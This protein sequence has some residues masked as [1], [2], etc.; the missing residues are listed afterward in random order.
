M[1]HL[2]F[3]LGFVPL[4]G[5]VLAA[6][7]LAAARRDP[8]AAGWKRPLLAVL[9]FDAVAWPLFSC[10]WLFGEPLIPPAVA[11]DD[12]LGF[13]FWSIW[14][15]VFVRIVQIVVLVAMALY[16]RKSSRRASLAL[17][18]VLFAML[19]MEV[20]STLPAWLP[21]IDLLFFK[22]DRGVRL[23]VLK[24]PSA[25]ALLAM[26]VVAYLWMRKRFD[27]RDDPAGRLSRA[28]GFGL[29]LLYLFAGMI[30]YIALCKTVKVLFPPDMTAPDPG[31][32]DPVTSAL[33]MVLARAPL[34]VLLAPLSEE[35][36]F[37]G[38][39]FPGLRS[40]IALWKAY[41]LSSLAFAL[42]HHLHGINILD[43]LWFGLVMAWARHRTGG[44]LVPI[45][46]HAGYNPY[47]LVARLIGI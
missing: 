5:V 46:L 22:L 11:D 3:G 4:L 12:G 18:W 19:A 24:G 43:L 9:I 41:L 7:G 25:L 27:A 47:V 45:L 32:D 40:R 36:L 37:R 33:S 31:G 23:L 1:F 13:T 2:A 35:M 42:M 14:G 29:G 44:L 20:A 34:T 17:R 16:L 10:V 8:A 6:V 39:L 28:A 15:T 21:N 26:A 30:R 38:V